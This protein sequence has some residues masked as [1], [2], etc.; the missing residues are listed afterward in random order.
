MTD[1]H[2][3]SLMLFAAG[4]GTRMGAL[5][6]EMPKP[7][8]KVAGRALID[9]ALDQVEGAGIA[10]TVVNLHYKSEMMRDQLANRNVVF[11]EEL[12]TI[13]E[14]GGGLRHALPLLGKSP[15]FTFNSDAIW[16]GPNPLKLLAE[17]WNPEKMDAL[18]LLV[19][20]QNARGHTG[21][22][23]FVVN[24]TG[25]L[26]RGPGHIYSGAQILCTERLSE[27]ADDV[28]S[29]N[30]LWNK[31]MAENRIYGLLYPGQ[32][33]D[34]GRPEGIAEAENLLAEVRDV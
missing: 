30:V 33:C 12:E 11:S 13:L 2:P 5:A 1:S 34:V 8:I 4:L 6:A 18:L 31:M 21:A 10:R 15:V 28:F 25:Q 9:H 23:D 7:L 32:W 27:I 14:T 20:P 24:A 17:A 3:N 22:G 16:A 26:T 29:L 19:A